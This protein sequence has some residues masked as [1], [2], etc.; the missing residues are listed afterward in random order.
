MQAIIDKEVD[1]M[2]KDGVIEPSGS[3]WSSPVV[4]GA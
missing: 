2:L 3:A 4:I 1:A